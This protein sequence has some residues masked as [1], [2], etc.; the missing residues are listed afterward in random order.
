VSGE[1][2]TVVILVILIFCVVP[3]HVPYQYLKFSEKHYEFEIRI[4]NQLSPLNGRL[5]LLKQ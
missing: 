3:T 5:R 1:S 4:R 2:Q